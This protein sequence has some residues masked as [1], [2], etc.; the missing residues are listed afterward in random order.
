MRDKELELRQ[1][2]LIGVVVHRRKYCK[3]VGDRFQL[4]ICVHL[5]DLQEVLCVEG[6][7]ILLSDPAL[8]LNQLSIHFDRQSLTTAADSVNVE[9]VC[10]VVLEDHDLLCNGLCL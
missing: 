4:F 6:A 7:R 2:R 3:V 9:S 10:I 8:G 5:Q 1:H